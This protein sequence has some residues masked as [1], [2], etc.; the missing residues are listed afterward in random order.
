MQQIQEVRVAVHIDLT[1]AAQ[2]VTAGHREGDPDLLVQSLY[3]DQQLPTPEKIWLHGVTVDEAGAYT[4]T[5]ACTFGPVAD[6]PKDILQELKVRGVIQSRV[7]NEAAK[8]AA[9]G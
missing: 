7:G 4:E 3:M 1:E 9:L 8:Q 6:L 5:K 2:F